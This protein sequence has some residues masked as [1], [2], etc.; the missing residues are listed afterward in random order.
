MAN[1]FSIMLFVLTIST[2]LIWLLDV[3]LWAPKRKQ[4]LAAA[5]A[6]TQLDLDDEVKQRIAPQHPVA[7]FAESIFPVIAFVFVLRSFLYEPFQI[8]SGSMIPTL[9]VGDFILVEKLKIFKF[10]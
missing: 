4:K 3:L 9:L 5:G 2:G 8:P 10:L 6:A 1:Y 7:E